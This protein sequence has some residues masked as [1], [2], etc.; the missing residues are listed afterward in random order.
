MKFLNRKLIWAV[1]LMCAAVIA[2]IGFWRELRI[3]SHVPLPPRYQESANQRPLLATVSAPLSV[4]QKLLLGDFTVVH[5]FQNLPD[6]CQESFLSSFSNPGGK[7]ISI[8]DI[9]NPGE[10]FQFSDALVPNLPYR[11]LVFAGQQHDK[12][13]IY[14]QDGGHMYASFCLAVID[15]GSEKPIWIGNEWGKPAA[16]ISELRQRLSANAFRDDSG[17]VC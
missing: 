11:R 13:F 14:Y 10:L 9:A 8:A 7:G 6:R 16:S 15:E 4:R 17:A 1:L 5:R 12:C 2:G 3:P